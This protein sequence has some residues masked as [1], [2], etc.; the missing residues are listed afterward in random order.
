VSNAYGNGIAYFYVGTISAGVLSYSNAVAINTTA[1]A[2]FGSGLAAADLNGDGRDELVVGAGV[3]NSISGP[4]QVLLFQFNPATSTFSSYQTLSDPAPGSKS[5]FGLSVALADVTGTS[6]LDLIVG[7]NNSTYVYSGPGFTSALVFPA[8]GAKV[9]GA[10]INGGSASDMIAAGNPALIFTGP[11]F[12]SETPA[13][14]VGPIPGVAGI[15][16]YD[17]VL[18]DINGDGMADIVV[19]VE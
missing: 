18:G 10:H 5:G 2:Y 11:V 17:L 15:W 7:G 3:V 6:D 4:N 19:G 12:S 13:F 1:I 14:G 8:A 16:L 9:G